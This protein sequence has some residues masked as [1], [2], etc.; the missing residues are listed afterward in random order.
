MV[1]EVTCLFHIF[2]PCIE[3]RHDLSVHCVRLKLSTTE[4]AMFWTAVL[5]IFSSA[6]LVK[7]G[8]LSVTASVLSM[9]LKASVATILF[10]IALGVW[11]WLRRR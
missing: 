3:K 9:A 11:M 1:T 8:A 2:G 10:F 5:I 6:V 4:I 7:L